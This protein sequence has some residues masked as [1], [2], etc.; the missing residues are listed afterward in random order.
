MVLGEPRVL[1][2]VLVADLAELDLAHEPVV[3]GVRVGGR[4]V[5]V[6]EAALEQAEFHDAEI[7]RGA[8][9]RF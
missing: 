1:P 9:W 6:N 8:E 2:V 3:L 5:L 7:L 4:D